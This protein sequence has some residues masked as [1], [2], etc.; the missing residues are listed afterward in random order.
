VRQIHDIQGMQVGDGETRADSGLF[1]RSPGTE[2]RG[3]T[4]SG[5]N[6]GH[7]HPVAR[8]ELART[9]TGA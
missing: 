6:G 1:G 9:R 8:R 4:F 5:P 3:R 7:D 2:R